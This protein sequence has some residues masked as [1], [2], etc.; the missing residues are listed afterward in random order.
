MSKA[1]KGLF[2]IGILL[3]IIL[4]SIGTF[5]GLKA[6]GFF[7]DDIIDISYTV[8]IE[9][10]KTDVDTIYGGYY[11]KSG[12]LKDGHYDKITIIENDDGT[13]TPLIN[14]YNKY[15]EDVSTE[16]KIGLVVKNKEVEI[17]N[18]KVDT[19]KSPYYLG[20]DRRLYYDCVT[21]QDGYFLFNATMFAEVYYHSDVYGTDDQM[22]NVCV[23]FSNSLNERIDDYFNIGVPSNLYKVAF[24]DRV[25]YLDIHYDDVSEIMQYV[26]TEGSLAQGERIEIEYYPFDDSYSIKVFDGKNV[27]RTDY[28]NFIVT[29]K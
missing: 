26:I 15:G 21:L 4:T 8:N 19:V 13:I 28:Y 16:Y 2:L 5:F 25:V 12:N 3:I 11:N 24:Q 20:Q 27:E 23:R 22:L 10:K 17:I 1:R 29:I 7:E 6:L 18:L 14:I 9:A